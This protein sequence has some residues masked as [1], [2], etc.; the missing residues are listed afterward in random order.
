MALQAVAPLAMTALEAG[1][2]YISETLEEQADAV[3]VPRIGCARNGAFPTFQLNI[4]STKEASDDAG[5]FLCH[6]SANMR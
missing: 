6:T 4:A 5:E 2:R 3:N 1:P